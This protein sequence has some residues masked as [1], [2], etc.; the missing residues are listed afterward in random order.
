MKMRYG[1]SYILTATLVTILALTSIL[2]APIAALSQHLQPEKAAVA[3][4]CDGCHDDDAGQNGKDDCCTTAA[5][6]CACHAPLAFRAPSVP[7]PVLIDNSFASFEPH[8]PSQVYL[9]IFVPP[10]NRS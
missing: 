7:L 2:L 8:Q 4:S 5:C 1:H 6:S 10:Q 3:A 9:P